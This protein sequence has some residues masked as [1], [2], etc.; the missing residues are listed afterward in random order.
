MWWRWWCW[1]WSSWWWYTGCH[2]PQART[3]D[4]EM[5]A[6]RSPPGTHFMASQELNL[7]ILS[8]NKKTKNNQ[9]QSLGIRF[10]TRLLTQATLPEW[11]GQQKSMFVWVLP[12]TSSQPRA[13]AEQA[14]SASQAEARRAIASACSGWPRQ[15]VRSDG[16]RVNL[17]LAMI[18]GHFWAP[19]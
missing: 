1:Y 19:F 3:P 13:R 12:L 16:K 5:K 7:R 17:N 6:T 14:P 11:I 9:N 2:G 18:L 4:L 15:P 8:H 10:P